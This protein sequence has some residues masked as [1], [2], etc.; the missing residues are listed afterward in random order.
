LRCYLQTAKK[1]KKNQQQHD[2][3][4][5]KKEEEEETPKHALVTRRG[6]GSMVLS[7]YKYV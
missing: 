4:L 1:E 6:Y 3:I 2:Q 5:N 7:T